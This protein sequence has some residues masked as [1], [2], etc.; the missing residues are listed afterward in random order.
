MLTIK[1]SKGIIKHTVEVN[2]G[3][4]LREWN[5]VT[6]GQITRISVGLSVFP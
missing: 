2:G 4:R 5:E 1:K 6:G 3:L